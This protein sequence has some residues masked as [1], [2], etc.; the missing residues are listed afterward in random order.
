METDRSLTA[1]AFKMI[2]CFGSQA[3]VKMSQIVAEQIA[4][5]DREGIAFWTE[6]EQRVRRF[7]GALARA[8]SD[9][10]REARPVRQAFPA[11]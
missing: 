1:I 9:E 4:A 3:P 10:E 6:I 11:A 5:G 2:D 7:Q 8:A